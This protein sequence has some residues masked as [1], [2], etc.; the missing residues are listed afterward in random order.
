MIARDEEIFLTRCLDNIGESAFE[1]L[2]GDTGSVDNTRE[3][4]RTSGAQVFDI[5]WA[6]D[7]SKARNEVIDRARGDWILVLD[8]DEVISRKDW[9]VIR[10]TALSG[11][12][13]G[14]RITTR[15]YTSSSD[16]AGWR[17]CKG[18]YDEEASYSG[19]FPTTKVR[20]FEKSPRIR[21]EGAL[22][23]LVESSIEAFGGGIADCLVPVHHYGSWKRTEPGR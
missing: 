5:P 17:P 10:K 3:V 4:A 15:N 8:C 23:E 20:L 18:E 21:F 7:F 19:W 1:I 11:R 14:Y 16:R 9:D 2:V 13:V 12:A 6:N 22:H